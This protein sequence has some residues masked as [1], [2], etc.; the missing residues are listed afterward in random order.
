MEEEKREGRRDDEAGE[1]SET[2]EQLFRKQ[3]NIEIVGQVRE[4]RGGSRV[5]VIDEV[6]GRFQG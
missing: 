1:G 3:I 4:Q 5:G 6:D 2:E